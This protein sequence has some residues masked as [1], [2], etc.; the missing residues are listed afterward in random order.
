[1]EIKRFFQIVF[2]TSILIGCM[3]DEIPVPASP[4]GDLNTSQILMGSDYKYQIYYDLETDSV[5]KQNYKTEWDLGFECNNEGWHVV[6]NTSKLMTASRT[7]FDLLSEVLD[8]NVIDGWEYDEV[9]GNLDS[10]AIGDWRG[11][12]K[13]FIIDRGYNEKGKRQGFYK[14]IFDDVKDGSFYFR[15]AELGS[16]EEKSFV[17]ST[18]PSINY[19]YFSFD[20]EGSQLALEP[21]KEIWDLVFTQYTYVFFDVDVPYLVTGALNN[22]YKCLAKQDSLLKFEDITREIALGM[23]LSDEIDIP[24][25]RWKTYDF[26][27]SYYEINTEKNYIIQ[28]A[29]GL[30]YKLRFIDF[31]NDSGENGYPK[32]E[33]QSL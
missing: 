33:F 22:P 27:N 19:M 7:S 21:D 10:T 31:Y 18:D 25:Y 2:L 8:T 13:V 23:D 6:L 16:T 1:M 17:L 9:S 3:K 15:F 28:T 5:I 24:G 11:F 32:F 29:T 14:I 30:Y 4:K 26:D 20:N 12:N